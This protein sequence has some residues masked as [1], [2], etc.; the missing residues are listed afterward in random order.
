MAVKSLIVLLEHV[1]REEAIENSSA[2]CY[3]FWVYIMIV[4]TK[5]SFKLLVC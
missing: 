2:G 5:Y 4:K 3:L 1:G